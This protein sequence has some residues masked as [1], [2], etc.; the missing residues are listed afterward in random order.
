MKFELQIHDM[1]TIKRFEEL[2]GWKLA[3]D[4]CTKRGNLIDN[5]AFKKTFVLLGRSKV[6]LVQ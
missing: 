5:N 3:R 4:L 2:D 1:P 6:H